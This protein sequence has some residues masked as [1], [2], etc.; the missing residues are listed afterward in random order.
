MKK[1]LVVAIILFMLPAMKCI[2][3][4]AS[5]TIV[6]KMVSGKKYI[7][8]KASSGDGWYSI[9]RQYGISYGDLWSENKNADD[10]ISAGDKLMIPF[11]SSKYGS[12]GDKKSHVDAVEAMVHR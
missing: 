1:Y 4:T 12:T 7:V 2:A 8:H 9:A 10:K 3:G 5:D 11:E 6:T